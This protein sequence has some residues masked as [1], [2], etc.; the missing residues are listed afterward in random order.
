[1]GRLSGTT[2]LVT[3]AAQG[4]GAAIAA[5]LVGEGVRVAINARIDDDRL[6]RVV[7]TTGGMP[8]PA[9]IADPVAVRTMVQEVERQLGPIEV[10]V[11]NAAR[12]TMRPFL[13]QAPGEWWEQVHINLS[14]HLDL[15]AAV[16]P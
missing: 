12:M 1:M 2:C 3:G 10:L 15:S 16:L 7:Q 9:D 13:E 14:G 11:Y 5:R 6:A 4:I 8:A